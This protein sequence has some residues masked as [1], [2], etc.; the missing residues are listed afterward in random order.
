[1]VAPARAC[2]D[3]N[4]K[5]RHAVDTHRLLWY[6]ARQASVRL[7]GSTVAKRLVDFFARELVSPTPPSLTNVMDTLGELLGEE[8]T[9]SIVLEYVYLD[10]ARKASGQGALELADA[11][12]EKGA[13]NENEYNQLMLTAKVVHNS[14]S[15]EHHISEVNKSVAII[16]RFEWLVG[17][18]ASFFL[19]LDELHSSLQ[20][21]EVAPKRKRPRGVVANADGGDVNK[22]VC[23]RVEELMELFPL[24]V[25]RSDEGLLIAMPMP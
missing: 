7:V 3:K 25:Q 5:S 15:E 6:V 18:L 24:K 23:K 17:N 22:R 11:L 2:S 19:K 14:V 1:M 4:A 13:I 12:L 8:L 21:D 16:R 10:D 20:E 9:Q